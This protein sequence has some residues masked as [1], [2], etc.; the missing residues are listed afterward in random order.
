MIA[1]LVLEIFPNTPRG[2]E[3]QAVVEISRILEQ[4]AYAQPVGDISRG[5][6]CGVFGEGTKNN[7][8]MPA[9]H[10]TFHGP[11]AA[12]A[13]IEILTNSD[14]RSFRVF[15]DPESG[16]SILD[17]VR[18]QR[19]GCATYRHSW[20]EDTTK[21]EVFNLHLSVMG[22]TIVRLF[23]ALN[24]ATS[25]VETLLLDVG[26]NVVSTPAR[27]ERLSQLI[28]EYW[29]KNSDAM[30]ARIVEW[31][32][33]QMITPSLPDNLFE[34]VLCTKLCAQITA[35][36]ATH[37]EK[38]AHRVLFD[39]DEEEEEEEEGRRLAPAP[40]RT[41]KTHTYAG[42]DL[43]G[44]STTEEIMDI[45]F[46]RSLKRQ[47]T[48]IIVMWLQK[49]PQAIVGSRNGNAVCTH[50]FTEVGGE[51]QLKLKIQLELKGVELFRF[52][53]TAR[54][55]Q[56]ED[57]D[58]GGSDLPSITASANSIGGG[59][60]ADTVRDFIATH[61]YD[62]AN[63]A[64]AH[65]LGQLGYDIPRKTVMAGA[66]EK[67]APVFLSIGSSFPTPTAGAAFDEQQSDSD[68]VQSS[69]EM[70]KPPGGS[71]P[72]VVD[73]EELESQVRAA[74]Q[75]YVRTRARSRAS[76]LPSEDDDGDEEPS[77]GE[78]LGVADS[79]TD[80]EDVVCVGELEPQFPYY[81]HEDESSSAYETE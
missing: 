16:E 13:I 8:D 7:K 19:R 43:V 48:D 67:L 63:N 65:I 81:D 2:V 31:V 39:S 35:Q 34:D 60:V 27:N 46:G 36:T 20:G 47:F 72:F 42:P 14:E 78:S 51:N 10:R 12:G 53:A 68:D 77:D 71:S 76:Q 66:L 70:W 1:D 58:T 15:D 28:K 11:I 74:S 59:T 6:V 18:A 50:T 57:G 26:T 75:L 64:M 69:G 29:R 9:H 23:I 56:G 54:S 25:A 30:A 41:K 17:M 80:D 22:V 40:K 5:D 3:T 38:R 61:A 24:R 79:D 55:T 49:K 4:V 73:D 33:S 37:R 62:I 52:E 32:T 45:L 44:L 21:S